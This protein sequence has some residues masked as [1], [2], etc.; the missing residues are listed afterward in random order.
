MA[1]RVEISVICKDN[2]W[3]NKDVRG[4][5]SLYTLH[6]DECRPGVCSVVVENRY[7]TILEDYVEKATLAKTLTSIVPQD[8]SKEW[9]KYVED[10]ALTGKDPLNVLPPVPTSVSCYDVE[11]RRTKDGVF[12]VGHLLPVDVQHY[13]RCQQT[14]SGMQVQG[15]WNKRFAP[16]EPTTKIKLCIPARPTL[17]TTCAWYQKLLSDSFDS[18]EKPRPKRQSQSRPPRSYSLQ[19][20]A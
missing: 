13:F 7:R 9:R 20:A 10:A 1:S 18:H 2:C 15:D 17:K 19:I 4:R 12:L 6:V 16:G 3:P 8:I 5:W 14:S 11:L